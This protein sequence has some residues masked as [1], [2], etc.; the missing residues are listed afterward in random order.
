MKLS[1]VR[2]EVANGG[3][4]VQVFGSREAAVD[5]VMGWTTGF[6]ARAGM[7]ADEVKRRLDADGELSFENA[8]AFYY[9]TDEVV[10]GEVEAEVSVQM[11]LSDALGL[12]RA[13]GCEVG[14]QHLAAA[15]VTLA[16]EV[17]RLR[18][19]VSQG[20]D[21]RC[22]PLVAVSTAHLAPSALD[23]LASG[24]AGA[25]GYPN[26]LGGFVHVGSPEEPLFGPEVPESV[27]A[28]ASW[29]REHGFVWIKV[30]PDGNEIEGLGQFEHA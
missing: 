19:E 21:D 9:L 25:I 3:N 15:A 24:A 1:V 14:G 29:A 13:S 2:F 30:D 18:Q 27:V 11:T 17:M 22:E 5:A 8:G 10:H 23:W 20:R 16:G 4:G 7:D 6:R 26:Q 28:V 12:A